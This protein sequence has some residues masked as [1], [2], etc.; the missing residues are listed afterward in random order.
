MRPVF[1]KDNDTI[2]GLIRVLS[3]S[4]YVFFFKQE[5]P[6]LLSNNYR[7]NALVYRA[8]ICLTEALFVLYHFKE[9]HIKVDVVVNLKLIHGYINIVKGFLI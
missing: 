6:L 9:E 8:C 3:P 2:F 7:G 5:V 1:F 4:W